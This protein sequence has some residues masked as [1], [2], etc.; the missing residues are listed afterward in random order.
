MDT[1]HT[2]TQHFIPTQPIQSVSFLGLGAMGYQM[3]KHLVGEFETV[4]VWNRSFETAEAHA[5]QFGTQAVSLAQAVSADVIFSCLPTSDVV[6]AIIEQALPHMQPGSVWVDCTSGVPDQAKQ[7]QHKLNAIG[8]QFI[9]APVSGQTSGADA[10]TLTVMV[11]AEAAA[12]DYA[13]PAIDCFAGLIVHVGGLGAG[14]A[15]KAVNNTL[16]AINAW[17]AAEGLSVL[18]AH[19]VNPSAALSCLN[20]ASGQSFATL[21]TFPDRIVNRT[22]P[23]TFTLDLMAK[24][25]GIAIDL[26]TAENVPTPVMAQVASLIRAA[27][28]QHPPGAVDFSEFAKFY[29]MLT[30]INI[31]D[32]KQ[33]QTPKNS[34]DKKA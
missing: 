4:M 20:K 2:S 3:A 30:G 15:V 9:D 23:K 24:D 22:F 29:E 18:K 7:S 12:L 32:S 31:E 21:A 8:C 27:S 33:L 10:G 6:D 28:N 19:G 26:Q 16:F 1:A 13:K 17:A 11:G 34:N 25:C 14:F 5:K